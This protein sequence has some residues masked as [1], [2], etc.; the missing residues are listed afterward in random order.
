MEEAILC[1]TDK[2]IRLRG[3]TSCKRVGTKLKEFSI[4]SPDSIYKTIA[5]FVP[6]M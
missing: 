4:V 2:S 6:G 1:R 3:F 5:S